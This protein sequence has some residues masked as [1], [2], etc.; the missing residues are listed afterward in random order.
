MNIKHLTI[1]CIAFM[2]LGCKAERAIYQ[3]PDH[4]LFAEAEHTFGVI[5]NEEWFEVEISAMRTANYDRNVGVEVITAESSATE[6]R[7]FTIESNTV[8]IPAGELTT[9]VRIRGIADNIGISEQPKIIL[10]LVLNEEETW[11]VYGTRAEVTLQRCCPFD[12]NSFEGYA[13]ITSTWLMQYMNTDS[14]LVETEVDTKTNTVTI[15]EMFYEG[16]DIIVSL[17]NSDRLA[18]R[19]IVPSE[20]VLGTTGE[21]FGTIYGNGKLM[22]MEPTGYSSY[23]GTCERFMVLYTMMYVDGV[24]T[25]GTYV[26]I[27]EWISDEEAERI[28]REG[29]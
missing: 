28:K 20:Q 13:K 26:N 14:R 21:A 4:I 1:I 3:G 5:D 15:K 19:V 10:E 23:Y 22:M 17:D 7:H 29:L 8:T 11:D 9:A 16:Y 12:I 24:G 6:N 25:V 27:F 18:P 2:L